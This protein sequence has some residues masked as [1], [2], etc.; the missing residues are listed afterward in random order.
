MTL[1]GLRKPKL[2]SD[3]SGKRKKCAEKSVRKDT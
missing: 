1:Q 2:D 3:G